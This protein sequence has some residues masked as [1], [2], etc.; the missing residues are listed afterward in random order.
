MY[1]PIHFKGYELVSPE[2]YNDHKGGE[3]VLQFFNPSYLITL[4]F[5]WE[6]F[7]DKYESNHVTINDWKW[8]GKFTQKGLRAIT[9]GKA[10]LSMHKWCGA[11]DM[12]IENVTA[13]EARKEI[14]KNRILFPHITRLE[15]NVPWLHIDFANVDTSKGIVTFKK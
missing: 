1:I 12:D 14:K 10:N 8:G 2:I 5:I 13:I 3:R 4:D 11:F 9:I 15:L 7:H 6:Y